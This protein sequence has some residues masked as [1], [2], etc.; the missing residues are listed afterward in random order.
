MDKSTRTRMA[1][2]SNA[3]AWL[4][5]A[6]A[7]LAGP[8]KDRPKRN[9]SYSG[10]K[11][12]LNLALFFILGLIALQAII[13]LAAFIFISSTQLQPDNPDVVA[14]LAVPPDVERH[15]VLSEPPPPATPT[16]QP[17]SIFEQYNLNIP[18]LKP[19]PAPVAQ[20]PA[21]IH[22]SA[23]KFRGV[24][25]TQGIQVFQEPENPRCRLDANH[26][27]YV[28]CNNSMPMVAG[29]HTLVR[30][31]LACNEYC[32]PTETVVRLRLLKDG[33]EQAG[34]T[35]QLS[36]E[37][38]QQ[39]SNLTMPE[40]RLRLD[41]S[42]N[43]EFFPPPSWLTG[44][45]DF[46]LEAVTGT[47][48]PAILSLT[49]NFA[50][51]R[52]LRIAYLPIEYQGLRPPDPVDVDYWLLRLYPVPAVE[53]YR[54]PMPD[55]VWNG[56][57]N[58]SDVLRKLLYT[59]WF[60]AQ[61][62]PAESRPD[63]L[64]G[65]LPKELYNGG[66]SD[67]FWCPN[68]AGPHSSRVAFGGLRP[69][70]DIGGPRILV[71]EIAH[72]LG[73]Q[74]AWSPTN[75]EDNRCF[76]AEGANIQ[77][78]PEWPYAQT[79]HIQ[80]FGIDLYS[81]P[82]VIYPPSIYD[83]MAYCTQPWISPHTYHKIFNSPFLQPDAAES[84]SVT[85]FEPQAD[86]GEGGAL[87]VSGVVYPN[88]TVS[89]P[90]VI[91]LG[92]DE[93]SSAAGGFTPPLEFTPPP[94]DDY[95]LDVQAADN[96]ML[97]QHCFDAGFVDLETGL[98]TEP[99]PFFFTLPNVNADDVDKVIISKNRVAV[100]IVTP[101]NNPPEVTVTFPN[102]GEALS[103]RQ[104]FTWDAYDADGDSLLYDVLYSPDGGQSWLPLAVRLA[105]P[106]YTFYTSQVLPS[107]NALIRVIANDGFHAT[108]DESDAAFVIQ[109]PP[110]NSISLIGPTTVEPGQIFEVD[111]VANRVANPGLFG[112]QFELSFDPGSIQA[113]GIRAHPA[114]A[115]VV[116]D[117]IQNDTGQISFVASRQGRVSNLTGQITLATLTFTAG[118]R[119]EQVNL[120]LYNLAA[121]ARGGLPV[122]ISDIRGL[123]LRIAQ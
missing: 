26:P 8:A 104:T 90:E 5:Q 102:G 7:E 52:P 119:E 55:V 92:G 58:K 14:A 98:P 62:S 105:E 11:S 22:T 40:L 106:D 87:L 38:L 112:I 35:R 107:D 28:L 57:V 29:R 113:E 117:T 123:S 122:S 44:Q 111:V 121:G 36:A 50:V 6:R 34:F 77:V 43:F 116:D 103:G 88:G 60:Y 9:G 73:A 86:A 85:N 49:K 115:S 65:W 17:Q 61:Y 1:N 110:E 93:F 89:R 83:M 64:F 54:L 39:I 79:P 78:D 30:V 16:P 76:K 20:A 82:P 18:D 67:P 13:L 118:Q 24:E 84:L 33:Q 66:V 100:V 32:P 99:S 37:T 96:T 42:V 91:R 59:Y 53:Y 68:C 41:N 94:G 74:H 10:K 114:L 70:Q 97:A 71:H 75:R 72:N 21:P 56:N 27:D 81:N 46:E 69:E 2:P 51:R 95:C 120:D 101:S 47:E 25:I 4:E 109:P 63:Q 45:V 3:R 80:E 15:A 12:N 31:Y 108:I 23:L 19:E 48:T